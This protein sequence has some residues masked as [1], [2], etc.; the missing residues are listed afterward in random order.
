MDSTKRPD[1][2]GLMT[3]MD[4]NDRASSFF[5]LAIAIYWRV[6]LVC[7]FCMVL[8]VVCHRLNFTFIFLL[9]KHLDC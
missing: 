2:E 7:G 9:K 1:L 8:G 5:V 6:L 4:C 3:Y